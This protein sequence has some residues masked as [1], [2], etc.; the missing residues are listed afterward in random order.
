MVFSF[1]SSWWNYKGQHSNFREFDV[2]SQ[3]L[4]CSFPPWLPSPGAGA[5]LVLSCL[6]PCLEISPLVL[7]CEELFILQGADREEWGQTGRKWQGSS[8]QQEVASLV[9]LL[10][11]LNL[12]CSESCLAWL[13]A[14]QSTGPS[15]GACDTPCDTRR[16]WRS[17]RGCA[18]VTQQSRL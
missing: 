1:S 17:L 12:A 9:S 10:F 14:A 15:P 16:F 8:Q 5:I 7:V 18:A 13:P 3:G 6:W 2:A 11:A 4:G